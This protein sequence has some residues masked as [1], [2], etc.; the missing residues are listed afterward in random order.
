MSILLWLRNPDTLVYKSGTARLNQRRRRGFMV[1][2][3]R[4]PLKCRLDLDA[5]LTRS[6]RI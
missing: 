5:D 6:R 4:N 3:D 2:A 1:V